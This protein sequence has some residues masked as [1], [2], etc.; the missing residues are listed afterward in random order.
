MDE[1]IKAINEYPNGTKLIIKKIGKYKISGVIDT[2]YET[3]NGE[4]F[5]SENYQE[6][7]SCLFLVQDILNV[8]VEQVDI[9]VDS[10]IDINIQDPPSEI[11][12]ESGK[13]IWKQA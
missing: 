13:V 3:D 9:E 8:N 10:L 11:C 2:I 6:F 12:L 5:D 7:Y 1:L 4:E